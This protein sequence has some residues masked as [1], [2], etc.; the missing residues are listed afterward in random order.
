MSAAKRL[1]KDDGALWVIGSYHNIFRMGVALQDLDFWL[2]NDVIWLKS[3]P[4]PNFKGRRFTNAHE[5]MIW[6]AKSAEGRYKF[7]YHAMKGLNDDLQMRSDWMIPLCTG[8]ERL[9]DEKGVKV[10][11]TQKPEALLAPRVAGLDRSG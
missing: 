8:N 6:A 3:N 5:T 7:N 11:P 9:K 10:H 2:L 1:L 4:M